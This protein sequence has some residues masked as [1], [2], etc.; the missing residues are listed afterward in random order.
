MLAVGLSKEHVLPL[1]SGSTH[2]DADIACINSPQSTTVSGDECAIDHLA[3]TLKEQGVFCRKLAVE[4]AYH[5][6]HTRLV[7]DDYGASL[8][9]I[10]FTPQSDVQIFSSVSGRLIDAQSIVPRYWV[11]NFVSPVEF[12]AAFSSLVHKQ[13]DSDLVILEIGPHNALQGP[14]RQI[15]T[16]PY[17][18]MLQRNTSAIT[19]SFKAICGILLAGVQVN[20]AAV[21]F[22]GGSTTVETLVDLPSYPWDHS[23]VHWAQS[24]QQNGPAERSDIIGV[25]LPDSTPLEPTWRNVVRVTEIPWVKDHVVQGKVLY[26]A[27]GFL[28]MAVEAIGQKSS[29]QIFDEILLKEVSIDRALVIPHNVEAV[30]TRISLRP[31]FRNLAKSWDEFSISS[32]VDGVQW[33]QNCNGLITTRKRTPENGVDDDHE[34][35]EEI[36]LPQYEAA[37][38]DSIPVQTQELYQRLE[39]RGLKFG[40]VFTN[41]KSAYVTGDRSHAEIKVPDTALSMP[42]GFEYPFTIHPATLDGFLHAVFPLASGVG[43]DRE[44]PVPTS[45]DSICISTQSESCPATTFDVYARRVED[46]KYSLAAFNQSSPSVDPR[47]RI[48]GLSFTSLA[49]TEDDMHHI[50]TDYR[51]AWTPDPTFS[52]AQHPSIAALMCPPMKHEMLE[53]CTFYLAQRALSD[54]KI[55]DKQSFQPHHAKLYDDLSEWV[56]GGSSPHGIPSVALRLSWLDKSEEERANVI[57]DASS[58]SLGI[59]LS[60]IGNH[61]SGILR[62]EDSALALMTEDDRL[63]R[64]Y[65]EDEQLK[66]VSNQIGY[67][68][69]L[70]GN[71]DPRLN[72]LEVGAGTGGATLPILQALSAQSDDVLNFANYHFTDVSAAFFEKARVK[73]EQWIDVIDFKLFDLEEDPIEQGFKTGS[74]DIIIAANVIHATARIDRT[75]KRLKHLLK[76]RGRLI[77][78]ETTRKSKALQLIFGTLPGWWSGRHTCKASACVTDVRSARA[79]PL[80]ISILV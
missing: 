26:P 12:S 1:L 44:T 32:T 38:E 34:Y 5:S 24:L 79:F 39:K 73:L 52:I 78:M 18:S 46:G 66:A 68:V 21:N 75:L 69:S 59:L 14:I 60:P 54:L 29:Q 50:A 57:S 36:Y 64:F 51:I 8:C 16:V 71:K 30:E 15:Q 48:A 74:Y 7:A 61:L 6:E 9:D 56:G 13:K 19:S 40:P 35:H 20:L 70:L 23:H 72:I 27:A 2:G 76:P 37:F 67:L 58:L 10:E 4:V 3:L 45:I 41:L 25:R 11:D 63:E 65:A 55:E 43:E 62:G 28:A 17:Y 22:P 33:I 31:N 77:L 49:Y 80:K 47:V 53:E 42:L